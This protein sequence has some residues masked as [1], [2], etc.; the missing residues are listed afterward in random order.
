MGETSKA[1]RRRAREGFFRFYCQ[2]SGIDIGCGGD[3]VQA[4]VR[5]W[6]L[7]EGDATLMAG[8]ADGR[9]G[10]VY[11]SHLLHLL[12]D[13]ITAIRNWWRILAKG[14]FFMLYLP[15]RGYFTAQHGE[16]KTL[17]TIDRNEP[18]RTWGIVPFLLTTIQGYEYAYV[19]L[20]ED[21]PQR[22]IE[23]VMR[24]L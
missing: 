19:V 17:W 18:P 9:Y 24:K 21:A 7:A 5:Q 20:T 1:T 23:L 13:P 4:N 11:S 8:E 16:A 6:D 15:E 3:P 10:Y 14:G 12:D 2:G 22:S